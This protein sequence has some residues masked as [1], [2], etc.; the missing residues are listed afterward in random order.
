MWIKDLNIKPDTLNLRQEK[1]GNTLE[2]T[3]FNFLDRAPRIQAIRLTIH[4]CDFLKLK[5]FN[6]EKDILGGT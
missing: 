5:D 3:G 4:K 6:K 1:V 2:S